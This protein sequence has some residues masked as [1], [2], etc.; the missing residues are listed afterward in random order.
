L[1][2]SDRRERELPAME[3][4]RFGENLRSNDVSREALELLPIK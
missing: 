3:L 4:A 2:T 1:P